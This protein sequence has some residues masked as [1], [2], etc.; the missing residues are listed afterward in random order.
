MLK[1]KGPRALVQKIDLSGL[2]SSVIEV[3]TYSE[4]PSQY[5]LVVGVGQGDRLD[6][7]KFLPM[8]VQPGDT[9]LIKPMCGTPVKVDGEAFHLL[10]RDDMLAII[11]L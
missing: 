11:D 8:D 6:S 4:Q 2:K 7:G 1:V 9:V 10:M 3:V 5:A